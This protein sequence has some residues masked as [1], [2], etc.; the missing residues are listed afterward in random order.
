VSALLLSDVSGDNRKVFTSLAFLGRHPSCGF[1]VRDEFASPYHAVLA[2]RDDGE[3]YISD[4]GSTNGTRVQGYR[5]GQDHHMLA[6]GD[7]IGIGR[8][9]LIAVP[10]TG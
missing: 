8:T 9:T 1:Q 5:I 4:L 2:P 6:R 3:W 7:R 10:V